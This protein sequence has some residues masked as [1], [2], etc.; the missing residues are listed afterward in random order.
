VNKTYRLEDI[1]I[2]V[3]VPVGEVAEAL[4]K[5][6]QA[7]EEEM[8]RRLQQY[9][10]ADPQPKSEEPEEETYTVDDC[11]RQIVEHTQTVGVEEM[12]HLYIRACLAKLWNAA[13]DKCGSDYHNDGNFDVYREDT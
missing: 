4:D 7:R 2:A 11:L 8:K 6:I 12:S 9:L 3:G 10:Y 5:I 1:S 13:L